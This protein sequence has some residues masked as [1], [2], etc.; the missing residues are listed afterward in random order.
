[1]GTYYNPICVLEDLVSVWDAANTKC[2]AS[3]WTN[4]NTINDALGRY[5]LT[6]TGINLVTNSDPNLNYFKAT[7]TCSYSTSGTGNTIFYNGIT[8]DVWYRSNSTDTFSSYGR[9]FDRGDTSITLGTT[10][11]YQF[12]SWVYAGGSRSSE[13]QINGIG[14]DG[15]WHN[16]QVT[17][18]GTTA[19]KY[20]DGTLATSTAKT[21]TLETGS[22]M[23]VCN[24]DGN[25]FYGDVGLIRVYKRGLTATEV[26]LNYNALRERFKN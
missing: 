6:G 1:M 2:F 22:V 15:L 21:G 9:I 19:A 8:V 7:G 23:T 20:L 17:Y 11:S 12:R 13:L 5:P 3:G 14:Q 10:S 26:A 24:G 16:A 18:D 4:G 25:I